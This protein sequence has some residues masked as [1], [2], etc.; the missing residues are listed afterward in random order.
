M[1]AVHRDGGCPEPGF[2]TRSRAWRPNIMSL[3]VVGSIAI[4]S[5]ET[6][7]GSAHDVL[8]GS[9]VY[10]SYA[11]GLFGDVRLVGGVGEDFPEDFHQAL[12]KRP[13]D[14]EGLEVLP[15]ETFRWS[16]RY[17]GDMAQ[18]E[19]RD[20]K[21]NVF[22]DYQPEVP[23]RFRDSEFVF[24][25]NGSPHTQMAV[26]EQMNSPTFILA[27][28]MNLWIENEREGLLELMREVDGLVL[29]DG[30]AR[31]L[32]GDPNLLRA[33]RWICER[34]PAYC[35]VKKGEHGSLLRGPQSVFVLPAF[36]PEDLKDPTGAG[37]SF[38]GGLMGFLASRGRVNMDNLKRG[39]AYG[40][41]TASFTLEDFSTNRLGQVTR[42]ELE[43]RMEAFLRCTQLPPAR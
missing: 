27:D 34:G 6:P 25:A 4:D 30:E 23:E 38:A 13:I 28:T 3:I 37:D 31:Q 19:T 43:E 2:W 26:L 12:Q 7:C 42:E 18:A 39:V 41:V 29:N 10:F 24:L 14:L 21:L 36:P 8:G 1:T 17:E 9:A 33:A 11:A 20:V 22:E 40:T 16:G 15:G 35:I 5:V 32:S